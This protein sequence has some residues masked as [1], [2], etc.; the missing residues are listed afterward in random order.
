MPEVIGVTEAD[1]VWVTNAGN[2]VTNPLSSTARSLALACA[3]HDGKE[4]AVVGHT[5]CRFFQ[6]SRFF[7]PGRLKSRDFN[8][9]AG[10]S[11]LEDFLRKCVNEDD[12][13]RLAVQNLRSSP[14]IDR[15][16]PIHGLIVDT[17]SGRLEWLVNGYDEPDAAPPNQEPL[18]PPGAP[19]EDDFKIGGGLP[20][21]G[22]G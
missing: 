1:F 10:E 20:P 21:I 19:M 12:N 2:V 5:D 3:I 16:I 13:V 18:P 11:Y 8:L 15:S 6:P 17:E 22:S 9:G 14:L 4:L 7:L